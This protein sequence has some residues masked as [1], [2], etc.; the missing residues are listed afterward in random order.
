[1]L[2][3]A[4]LSDEFPLSAAT[5]TVVVTEAVELAMVAALGMGT[6]AHHL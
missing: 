6:A 3:A 5:E 1:M 2:A 4:A